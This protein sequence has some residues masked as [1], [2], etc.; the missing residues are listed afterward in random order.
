[1]LAR[2]MTDDVTTVRVRMYNVG[3][4]D[5]F[6][7]TVESGAD[8]W[9]MLVDCGVH[10]AGEA[11]NLDESVAQIIA[12]LPKASPDGRAHVDVIVAS[13]QHRD[14]IAGFADPAWKNV[15]VGEVWLPFVADRGDPDT[16]KLGGPQSL[17]ATADLLL[18]LIDPT[19]QC[20]DGEPPNIAHALAV[21]S[22]SKGVNTLAMDRLLGRDGSGF[23][24]V[25][26]LRF[27][28]GTDPTENTIP[29]GRCG[30][31]AHILGPSRDEAMLKKMRPP[32]NAGWLTLDATVD[33]DA[34][35]APDARPLFDPVYSVP[36]AQFHEAELRKLSGDEQRV[37]RP[38]REARD[39]M[40]LHSVRN[41]DGDLFAAAAI[42]ERAVN[43]TSL[44]FVLDVGALSFLFPGDAQYGAWEHVRANP[45]AKALIDD[46]DFYKVGHHGSHNATPGRFA[47]DDWMQRGD[48]MVPWGEVT[49]WKDKIPWPT[50]MTQLAHDGERRVILPDKVIDS[51][52]SR[53]EPKL[54]FDPDGRWWTELTYEVAPRAR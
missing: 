24:S 22:S 35:R 14:H 48:A 50:L 26:R 9:T 40:K 18:R 13:H 10:A 17:G 54:T 23:A 19:G 15:S 27:L 28:P 33:V 3:F 2:K 43:N 36:D 21:N 47:T 37:L 51:E 16:I 6:R 32:K 41:V 31:T 46:V 49:I 39:T 1:M 8:R 12:D 30:I 29:I 38:L 5:A 42:L 20:L 52:P 25:P 11:R 53:E 44:F 4:G 45:A 7:I 34:S